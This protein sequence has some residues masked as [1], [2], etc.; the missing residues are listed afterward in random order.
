MGIYI[1]NVIHIRIFIGEY[2]KS[3]GILSIAGTLMSNQYGGYEMENLGR[4]MYS[5]SMNKVSRKGVAHQ[6]SLSRSRR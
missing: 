5:P 1:T 6:D 3:T 2:S 4:K